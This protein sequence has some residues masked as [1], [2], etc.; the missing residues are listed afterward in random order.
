MKSELLKYSRIHVVFQV[1]VFML[2][3]CLWQGANILLTDS[4]YV[5]L[6]EKRFKFKL[7]TH[8][9]CILPS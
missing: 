6:G 5:K 3:I 4:G 2:H 7:L 9:A 8:R 1:L